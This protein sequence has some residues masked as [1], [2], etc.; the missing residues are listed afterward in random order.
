MEVSRQV[1][2]GLFAR[3]AFI[4]SIV[5]SLQESDFRLKFSSDRKRLR[6]EDRHSEGKQT[7]VYVCVFFIIH[8]AVLLKS[9]SSSSPL[10]LFPLR[11]SGRWG[12]R[13][14]FTSHLHF[15]LIWQRNPKN[16]F[17]LQLDPYGKRCDQKA[18]RQALSIAFNSWS[19]CYG[20][21]HRS[22]PD[23]EADGDFLW[24]ILK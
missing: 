17:V 14:S 8:T 24:L 16:F 15:E 18:R 20:G 9:V 22:L 13:G 23:S 7:V 2:R 21:F 6:R 12:L 4:A 3:F 5:P 10:F 11:V 19:H 1:R